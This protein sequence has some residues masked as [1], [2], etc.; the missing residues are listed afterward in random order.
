MIQ[1]VQTLDVFDRSRCL[2]V[3]FF[4]V[5]NTERQMNF[6]SSGMTYKSARE[7]LKQ[8][9]EVMGLDTLPLNMERFGVPNNLNEWLRDRTYQI[10]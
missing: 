9:G 7:Y 4:Y 1:T 3:K 5:E 2:E 8:D 6:D 10:R